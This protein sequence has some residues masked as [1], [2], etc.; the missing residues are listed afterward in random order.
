MQKVLV[1]LIALAA[2][3]LAARA[4]AAGIAADVEVYGTLVPHLELMDTNG[5]TSLSDR[6]SATQVADAAFTGIDEPARLRLTQGTSHLGF[7]GT[8]DVLDDLKVV[9]Q[10][11]SGVPIDGDPVLNT[12]ASRNSRLGFSGPWGTFFFGI[13]DNPYKWASLPVI[14]PIAAGFVADY[15]ALIGSPGFNVGALNLSPGY[16]ANAVPGPSPVPRSNAAFYRR[17]SNS[18]QYWSPNFYGLSLRA[19]Y[20]T[21]EFSRAARPGTGQTPEV[22]EIH[23]DIFSGLLSYDNGPL[24]LRYAIEVHRD[25]FGLS[26]IGG[27]PGG[28]ATNASSQDVGQQG[29][30]SYTFQFSEDVTTRV[31]ATFDYLFYENDDNVANDVDQYQR[32]SFYGLLDQSYKGHH[33]WLAYGHADDGSCSLVGDA[34]CSTDGLGASM[35]T[36]GYLYRFS[37]ETDIYA[38]AYQVMNNNAASYTPF[39]PIDPQP[40]PGANVRSVGIGFLHHFSAYA[41]TKQQP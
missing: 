1:A 10:V 19:S 7:R 24:K 21:N 3:G 16:V 4:S 28:T 20:T 23:P 36:L 14:N 35:M 15:T 6:A 34:D 13:W 41:S 31:V 11:E 29:V 26:L 39:P 25:Y 9:W 5:A 37:P 22:P 32:A 27:A 18:I 40:A 30:A 12:F 8:V 2:N 33:L 38:V 17:D